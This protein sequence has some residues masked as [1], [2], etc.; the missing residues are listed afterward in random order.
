MI[1]Q[2]VSSNCLKNNQSFVPSIGG[3]WRNF[4]IFGF[5][6]FV[7]N[8]HKFLANNL[9]CNLITHRWFD[10]DRVVLQRTKTLAEPFS[11]WSSSHQLALQSSF[12]TIVYRAAL[13]TSKAEHIVQL[14]W[15]Y[16][17]FLIL[18][19]IYRTQIFR[20]IKGIEKFLPWNFH[21][22]ITMK[23][24]FCFCPCGIDCMDPRCFCPRTKI[25]R[26]GNERYRPAA[27]NDPRA[28]VA[29]SLVVL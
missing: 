24:F 9:I 21:G 12:Q 23:W 14:S 2:W 1:L 17:I 15:N 6:L 28:T 3:T 18:D 4:V 19:K 10:R 5:P 27:G 26:S 29:L 11:K 22:I 25:N 7:V 16:R 8:G 20:G 13:P